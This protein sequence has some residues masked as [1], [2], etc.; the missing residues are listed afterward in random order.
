MYLIK[1]MVA[2]LALLGAVALL[3][4]VARAQVISWD[5][6]GVKRE[7]LV[8][9]PQKDPRPGKIPVIFAFHWHF[10]TMDQD[11]QIFHF[12]QIWPEALVVYPQ[13]LP[14]RPNVPND[15]G[16]QMAP[17]QQDDRDLKFFDV[18]LA[19]L[20]TK[21]PIDEKR[22]Y[23]AGFSNGS[24]LSYVL[25]GARAKTFAGFA[26]VAGLAA[27]SVKLTAPAPA[28]LVVGTMDPGYEGIMK[29]IEQVKT[30]NGAT[31][32][33]KPCGEGCTLYASTKGAPVT[34]YIHD[35]GHVYPLSVSDKFVEF[36]KAHSLD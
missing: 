7:A 23:A 35:H 17:G 22:I 27:D 32:E 25:W 24:R 15:F 4:S 3:P 1:R 11:A 14:T 9:V 5:V 30:L 19:D 26:L 36:F 20:K 12:Q 29:S 34:T 18:M 21:F 10:G 16:W 2:V 28:Y 33:G 31:G 8:F 6:D 13:G